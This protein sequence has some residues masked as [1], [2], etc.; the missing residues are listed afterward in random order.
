M[1]SIEIMLVMAFTLIIGVMYM[2]FRYFDDLICGLQSRVEYNEENGRFG[3]KCEKEALHKRVDL[4]EQKLKDDIQG[5]AICCKSAIEKLKVNF[6]YDDLLKVYKRVED[7]ESNKSDKKYCEIL[8]DNSKMMM[9][10]I[11]TRLTRVEVTLYSSESKNENNQ[12]V[13][14][15]IVPNV[16]DIPMAVKLGNSGNRPQPIQFNVKEKD[17][18]NGAIKPTTKKPISS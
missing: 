6:G 12:R 16:E 10:K 4:L 11:E 13:I 8:L 17:K 5:N 15:V 14:S 18:D 1:I 3:L 7:I 2:S 9:K